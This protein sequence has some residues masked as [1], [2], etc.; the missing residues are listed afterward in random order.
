MPCDCNEELSNAST[1]DEKHAVLHDW[2]TK[3]LEDDDTS[4]FENI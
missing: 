1:D 4:H 2:F 3:R